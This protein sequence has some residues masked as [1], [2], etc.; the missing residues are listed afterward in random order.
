MRHETG[1]LLSSQIIIEFLESNSKV[2]SKVGAR[3]KHRFKCSWLL[4]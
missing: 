3:C 1:D 4:S 2:E